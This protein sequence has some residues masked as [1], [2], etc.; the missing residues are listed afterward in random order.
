M[1]FDFAFDQ[2]FFMRQSQGNGPEEPVVSKMATR[3]RSNTPIPIKGA[4]H[5]VL[6]RDA[7]AFQPNFKPNVLSR[8]TDGGFCISLSLE[9][10]GDCVMGRVFDPATAP[11]RAI[12]HQRAFI[13]AYRS[14]MAGVPDLE[15]KSIQAQIGIDQQIT[16]R[17]VTRFYR[18]DSVTF[19]Y[20]PNLKLAQLSDII[21]ALPVTRALLINMMGTSNGHAV[22]VAHGMSTFRYFDSNQGQFSEQVDRGSH[23]FA[24]DVADNIARKYGDL[25]T[26]IDGYEVYRG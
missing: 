16:R 11:Y 25:Q 22:S 4:Q 21:A 6:L 5:H 1:K 17:Y 2:T 20:R 23:S 19:T 8:E 14:H 9:W 12:S 26:C 3:P 24:E 15:S 10:C 7:K 13:M 18:N